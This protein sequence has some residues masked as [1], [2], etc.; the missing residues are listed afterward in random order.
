MP[1]TAKHR[2][3]DPEDPTAFSP[4]GLQALRDSAH[5]LFWLIDRGYGTDSAAELVGDRHRLTRRQ[6]MALVRCAC[7]Q[8]VVARRRANSV[9]VESINHRELWLDGFN[10]LAVLESALGGGVV[11]RGRDGCYRDLAG[12]HSHYK[13]VEE[14]IPAL[15]AVFRAT[16]KLGVSACH[17]LLD[18][19]VSNSGR[20]R[21]LVRHT[22]SEGQWPWTV[23]V[24]PSPDRSLSEANGIVCTSDHVIL[25]RCQQWFNLVQAVVRNEI[26]NAWVVDL[27]LTVPT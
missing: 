24:V 1:K 17:W 15:C 19:P 3:A 20:L 18:Q 9:P 27:S 2:G 22:A 12:L 10:I 25:D 26:P 16:E 5:D 11:L 7:S 13:R 21:D 14:T 6:R 8:E 23:E 4:A